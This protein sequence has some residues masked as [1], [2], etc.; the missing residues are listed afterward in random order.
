MKDEEYNITLARARHILNHARET[1]VKRKDIQP[2][3]MKITH[4]DICE[5]QIANGFDIGN[6]SCVVGETK[7][8]NQL[9]A[10][11]RITNTI[12]T[13][14]TYDICPSCALALITNLRE[15]VVM[16]HSG[17]KST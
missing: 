17:T 13:G 16:K 10:H 14:P 15:E 12:A 3:N 7:S 6:F 5:T 4:C 2:N 11:L 1:V 8:K 9:T